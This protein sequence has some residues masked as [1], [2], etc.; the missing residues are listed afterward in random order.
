MPVTR[1]QETVGAGCPTVTW[2]RDAAHRTGHD[3]REHHQL[4]VGARHTGTL[5][6]PH[7]GCEQP[8][9]RLVPGGLR[10]QVVQDLHGVPQEVAQHTV[11]I[12][13]LG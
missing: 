3:L 10:R 5:Q 4:E 8:L 12:T 1:R 7:C 9:Q 11:R 6:V 13:Q 2:P